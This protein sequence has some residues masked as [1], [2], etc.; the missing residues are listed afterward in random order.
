M[1]RVPGTASFTFQ[2]ESIECLP[3]DRAEFIGVEV[4]QAPKRGNCKYLKPSAHD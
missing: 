2:A 4:I 1:A 3:C